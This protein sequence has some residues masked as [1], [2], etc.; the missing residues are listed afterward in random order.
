[1]YEIA[2]THR[3]KGGK[4]GES[5]EKIEDERN[6]IDEINLIILKQILDIGRIGIYPSMCSG[7][8][9]L[10]GERIEPSRVIRN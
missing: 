2:D 3:H 8:N 5:G 1:V 7:Q 6:H 9:A 10:D 4:N